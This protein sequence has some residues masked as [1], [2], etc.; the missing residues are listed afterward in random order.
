MSTAE[1]SYNPR[2]KVPLA[3]ESEIELPIAGV[4]NVPLRSVL[5]ALIACIPAGFV[6]LSPFIVF[7]ARAF[8]A[9]IIL[10]AAVV[11]SIPKT[12]GIWVGTLLAY[13]LLGFAIPSLTSRGQA[14]RARN[15]LENDDLISE[16]SKA[17]LSW[18]VPYLRRA[19]S[20][21]SIELIEDGLFKTDISGYRGV[22]KIEGPITAIG[23]LSYDNWGKELMS[24]VDAMECPVQFFS[25]VE[26]YDGAKAGKAFEQ[27]VRKGW[28]QSV[29]ITAEK[30]QVT[31]LAERSFGLSSYLVLAPEAASETGMMYDSS[32]MDLEKIYNVP[33]SLVVEKLT[34]AFRT[35]SAF[36]RLKVRF[37]SADE[38]TNLLSH[39]PL[40]STRAVATKQVVQITNAESSNYY[41]PLS[42]TKLARSLTPGDIVDTV[43]RASCEAT[44]SVIC[45]PVSAR[46][47]R[48]KIERI[49]QTR[50]YAA[51]KKGDS[52]ITDTMAVQEA[53]SIEQSLAE[54]VTPFMTAINIG[55]FDETLSGVEGAVERITALLQAK[56]FQVARPSAPGLLPMIACS[57]GGAPLRR[58]CIMTLAP[59]V[60]RCLPM[61]GTPFN[62][63]SGAL[64]GVNNFTGSPS[65]IDIWKQNT[66]HNMLIVANSGSGKSVA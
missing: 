39:S 29:I 25:I 30:N 61:L 52:D 20:L 60:E 26:H 55:V 6:F 3:I 59:V 28:G 63:L 34:S 1:K 42:V 47:A 37:A 17:P 53:R 66:N 5:A 35:A 50:T 62:D 27:R 23:G 31:N 12:Q 8:I 33:K 58:S 14:M 40:G 36:S 4:A 24:W 65:Y 38:I 56:T 21:P 44:I 45:N 2:I 11:I 57:L 9:I 51:G 15:Y 22:L 54:G 46:V 43:M 18:G 19:F 32:L 49:R 64:M 41:V 10:V 16:G 48:K 7:E 13:R